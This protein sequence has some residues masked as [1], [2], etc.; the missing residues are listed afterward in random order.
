MNAPLLSNDAE[1]PTT[2]RIKIAVEGE[3]FSYRAGQAA[4]LA[5]ADGEP[6]PYSIASAPSDTGR[7]GTLEFLVK[8]DGASRF[9]AGVATLRPGSLV[10][11][12]GPLG[13]FT[14]SDL[15]RRAPLLF[16]AGGTGIAPLRS[17][18]REA[19]NDGHRGRLTLLYSSR[20]PDEFAYL[21]E[22]RA[23][24]DAGR[25]ALTLT[26]TGNATE[27]PH[28]RGRAGTE[29][30]RE[31]VS[32]DSLAFVCGPRS[33]VVDVSQTLGALGIPSDA[34]RTEDW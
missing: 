27:W 5:I 10:R 15:P 31:L 8:V 9:G 22:W 2:R 18:I 28:A 32:A 24:A 13:A 33:M 6:T 1:T 7:E 29:H 19:M 23:L 21:D 34:I 11:V 26:L 14:G 17:I 4:S 30:L 20:T 16:V 25:L 12:T 3:P